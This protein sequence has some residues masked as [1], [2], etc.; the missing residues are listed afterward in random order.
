[1]RETLE[2]NFKK[3]RDEVIRKENVKKDLEI[4]YNNLMGDNHLLK[5][6]LDKEKFDI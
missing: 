4:T 2:N 5:L 6:D 1:M 3:L